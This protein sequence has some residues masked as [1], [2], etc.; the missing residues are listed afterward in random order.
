MSGN[1]YEIITSFSQRC[2][3]LNAPTVIEILVM[4]F[5]ELRVRLICLLAS[6]IVIGPKVPLWVMILIENS[7]GRLIEICVKNQSFKPKSKLWS[8]PAA[9]FVQFCL[10]YFYGET[11]GEIFG[12]TKTKNFVIYYT[13][14]FPH[15]IVIK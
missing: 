13:V 4:A 15:H 8:Q 5:F 1:Y 6:K 12:E 7:P 3:T 14:C 10:T 11:F 2:S 9:T